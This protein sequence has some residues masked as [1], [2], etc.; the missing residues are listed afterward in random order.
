M[1]SVVDQ[2]NVAVP[3][4]GATIEW[5]LIIQGTTILS[6]SVGSGITISNPTSGQFIIALTVNDTR[7]LHGTYEHMARVTTIDGNSSIVVTGTITIQ[8]SLI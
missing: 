6:K 8:E 4:T 1:I 3:L 5:I 7:A 2:N